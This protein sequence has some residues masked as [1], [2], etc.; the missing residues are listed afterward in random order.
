[1]FRFYF[2]A[3]IKFFIFLSFCTDRT[4]PF[5]HYERSRMGT[6][7]AQTLPSST[8]LKLLHLLIKKIA[9][10]WHICPAEQELKIYK[11][12]GTML[13]ELQQTIEEDDIACGT[14]CGSGKSIP[15]KIFI[16]IGNLQRGIQCRRPD[17]HFIH[18]K[19]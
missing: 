13:P 11:Q 15:T 17:L 9:R 4:L 10:S 12:F 16:Y 18:H 14:C 5:A 1:M 8:L 7:L 2:L 19:R 3:H 6:R